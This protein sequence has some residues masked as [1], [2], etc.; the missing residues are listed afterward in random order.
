MKKLVWRSLSVPVALVLSLC[1]PLA[2]CNGGDLAESAEGPNAE[3]PNEGDSP[4]A[5]PLAKPHKKLGVEMHRLSQQRSPGLVKQ[6][7][8]RGLQRIVGGVA[9]RCQIRPDD[10]S[11]GAAGFHRDA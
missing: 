6:A 8:Q 7:R 9:F 10:L 5:A 2:A 3:G 4:L 11:F 1:L